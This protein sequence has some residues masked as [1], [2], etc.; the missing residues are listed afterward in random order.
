MGSLLFQKCGLFLVFDSTRRA[1]EKPSRLDARASSQPDEKVELVGNFEKKCFA[2]GATIIRQ[3]DAG[4]EFYVVASGQCEAL[5]NGNSLSVAT[6]TAGMG[7]G[8]LAL[9]YNTPRAASIVAKTAVEVWEITRAEYR[10]VLAT[11]AKTRSA[12]YVEL[13][14]A[15]ELK[16]DAGATKMLRDC[17]TGS[18]MTKLADCMDEDEL[19]AGDCIINEGDDGHTHLFTAPRVR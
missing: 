8:E 15:V 4:H 3:G 18:Q 2:A 1:R 5:L 17:I 16:S 10:F 9:M 13:L 12:A 7:F 6:Q 14:D 19:S 11:F